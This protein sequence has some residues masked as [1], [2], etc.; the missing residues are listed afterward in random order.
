M[1]VGC[2]GDSES[3]ETPADG[4]PSE[5]ADTVAQPPEEADSDELEP[6]V[7]MT[8]DEVYA[9][10]SPSIPLIETASALGSGILIEG[11]YVVTNYH[12]VWPYDSAWVVFPDG[13]ELSDVPVI[14]WDPLVDL[15]VL[16]P[17]NASA[18]ALTLDSGEDLAIGSALYLLGYPAEME[19]TPE[20]SITQG[21]LTRLRQWESA[22]MTYFQSDAA[23]AGGQSGG[24]LIDASGRIVGITTYSFSDANFTLATSAHDDA[25][26]VSRLIA[27]SDGTRTSSRRLPRGAERRNHEVEIEN[28]WDAAT[29]VFESAADSIHAVSI[30]GEMD[31]VLRVIDSYGELDSADWGLAGEGETLEFQTRVDGLHFLEVSLY[32]GGS[33]S[34]DVE[35]TIPMTRLVDPDDDRDIRVGDKISGTIDYLGDLDWYSLALQAGDTV[36]VTT[37]SAGVDTQISVTLSG[38]DQRNAAQDDDSSTEGFMGGHSN[39][40]LVF[41]ARQGGTYHIVVSAYA[42]SSFGGYFLHVEEAPEGSHEFNV[43]TDRE[44]GSTDDGDSTPTVTTVETADDHADFLEDAT[45][46]MV[47]E[48]AA[49]EIDY[50]GDIDSFVFE[51]IAGDIYQ[52]DVTLGTLEDSIVT[53]YDSDGFLLESNDDFGDTL[54]SR[55]NWQAQA[56]GVFYVDVEGYSDTGS[57]TLTI[58]E[59]AEDDDLMPTVT[60]T[61]ETVDIADDHADTLEDA[62]PVTIGEPALGE[63]DFDGDIDLFVFEGE[64]GDSYQIDVILGTLEDSIAILFDSEWY[65]LEYNDDHG[66]TLASRLYWEAESSESLYVSVEGYSGTG[67]YTLTV[68]EIAEIPDE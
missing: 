8:A 47:G 29:F 49:G 61:A 7:T 37:D 30:T 18:P 6:S 38:D 54:A 43:P 31:G 65:I 19:R 2:G 12:V 13:L 60:T 52:I 10:L 32:E 23:I 34:F 21:I 42:S 63:M 15:A 45:P 24:A 28:E 26:I 48:P 68:V 4:T 35:S 25:A 59:T 39:A 57:Y 44:D 50:D 36:R 46:V 64:A 62:T 41:R 58:T 20:V 11:G 16:G 27:E 22:D 56:S 51:G 33:A 66:D 17:V 5:S 55:I 1:L 9:A 40:E 14:G 53:L 3:S 67:S